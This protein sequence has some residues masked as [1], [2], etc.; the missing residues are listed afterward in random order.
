MSLQEPDIAQLIETT[1]HWNQYATFPR[2]RRTA[3][4]DQSK[5]NSGRLVNAT[6]DKG[7]D[8]IDYHR[9]SSPETTDNSASSLESTLILQSNLLNTETTDLMFPRGRLR[10]E[11]GSDE[12]FATRTRSKSLTGREVR[13]RFD[14]LK[15]TR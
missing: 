12:E 3:C 15:D 13:P 14:L 7:S 10:R 8:D 11:S 9:V 1:G 4:R 6:L 2:D 5:T